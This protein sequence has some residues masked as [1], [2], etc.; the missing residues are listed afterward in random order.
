MRERENKWLNAMRTAS[1]EIRVMM[2]EK[3]KKERLMI[4]Y[5]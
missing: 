2:G 3:E 5:N 4:Y 1:G